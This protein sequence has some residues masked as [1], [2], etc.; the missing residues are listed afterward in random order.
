M[1]AISPRKAYDESVKSTDRGVIPV[2]ERSTEVLNNYASRVWERE[3]M[4][5][6]GRRVTKDAAINDEGIL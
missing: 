4:D 3:K 2:N 1:I 5:F 6:K